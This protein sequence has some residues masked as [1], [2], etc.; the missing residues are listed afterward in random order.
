M[1]APARGFQDASLGQDRSR[2]R[3]DD[4]GRACET[5]PERR[6]GKSQGCAASEGARFPVRRGGRAG[7]C[8]DHA[9]A[10]ARQ[11]AGASASCLP[12]DLSTLLL[13]SGCG[14]PARRPPASL[15]HPR[16]PPGSTWDTCWPGVLG[17]P[18]RLRSRPGGDCVW[19]G[20]ELGESSGWN[21]FLLRV[22]CT[23]MCAPFQSSAFRRRASRISPGASART[24][25]TPQPTST[26][27][28]HP[29][30]ACALAGWAE[31]L[32]SPPESHQATSSLQ[33]AGGTAGL[34]GP[35]RDREAGSSRGQ[36]PFA[37][38]FPGTPASSIL[39]A[40]LAL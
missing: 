28:C 4:G 3:W 23:R 37:G 27:P 24:R 8:R 6:E 14:E 20:P 21:S 13:V 35:W 19:P 10:P 11:E 18:H 1:G 12:R 16:P 29:G 7:V 2:V 34:R 26:R 17:R 39:T 32:P 22:P 9:R 31:G 25:L 33:K 5:L 36:T 15:L 38:G 40:H 30:P